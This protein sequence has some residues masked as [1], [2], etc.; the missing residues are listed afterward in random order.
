MHLNSLVAAL[1]CCGDAFPQCFV[2]IE[3]QKV[4]AKYRELMQDAL[5]QSAKITKALKKVHL[6]QDNDLK[7]GQSKR[8]SN[9][10]VNILPGLG[11]NPELKPFDNWQELFEM[12]SLCMSLIYA[13]HHTNLNQRYQDKSINH[14]HIYHIVIRYYQV[15]V[16]KALNT[17]QQFTG[18]FLFRKMS[19]K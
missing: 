3:E 9:E 4:G 13:C 16:L 6:Q 10:K 15:L 17:E 19:D 2:K 12:I 8:P 7:Q 1:L 5:F 14:Y 11:Q 18:L